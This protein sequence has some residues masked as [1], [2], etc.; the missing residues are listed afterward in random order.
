MADNRRTREAGVDRRVHARQLA[1][2]FEARE[3]GTQVVV[4]HGFAA[5]MSNGKTR[6]RRGP[7]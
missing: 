2:A 7:H 3:E 4:V 5:E 6:R 1:I